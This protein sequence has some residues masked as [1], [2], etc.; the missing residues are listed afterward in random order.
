MKRFKRVM[1]KIGKGILV[2]IIVLAVV[3]SIASY[4]LGR[5]LEA[6]IAEIKAQG[7]PVSTL[8]LGRNTVPDSEN[9]AGIYLKIFDKMDSHITF[10]KG[11][12]YWNQESQ[13]PPWIRLLSQAKSKSP[14]TEVWKATRESLADYDGIRPLVDKA[15]S[16]PHCIFAAN[17]EDAD[18]VEFPH[19]GKM[20]SIA[21]F[22]H[23]SALV[24]AHYDDMDAAV[25]DT[26]RIFGIGKSVGNEPQ[27]I[28]QLVRYA[29][30]K[31]GSNC[32]R[33]LS[34]N[35]FS[36]NQIALLGKSFSG[37]S[38][39]TEFPTVLKIERAFSIMQFR[40]L[41]SG[42]CI[43]PLCCPLPEGDLPIDLKIMAY[44]GR[45]FLYAGMMTYLDVMTGYINDAETQVPYRENRDSIIKEQNEL[46]NVAHWWLPPVPDFPLVRDKC[47]A[48][49]LSCR[50]MLNLVKYKHR[51]SAYPQSLDTLR[52]KLKVDVPVDPMS[53][54]DFIY[55]RQG[56]G[57][58]LYSIG[59]N[60]RDD[61]GKSVASPNEA[62]PD[63]I[64]WSMTK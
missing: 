5:R 55:K 48:G 31:I 37:I 47:E 46:S 7:D 59:A 29:I 54:K 42:Q 6:R 61:G 3:H 2:L 39:Y 28:G 12:P 1:K 25:G 53:G 41:L 62:E 19:L 36:E 49:I 51:F 13:N 27:M 23:A 64:V 56:D 30:I 52:S 63:D 43:Y 24:N 21:R 20:R 32:I 14:T 35:G 38:V 4:I 33:D 22:Y 60:M 44:L 9:A 15:I 50:T 45:P 34:R 8:D 16:M 17:W 11:V 57:F 10:K 26:T 40:K 58:L 18:E